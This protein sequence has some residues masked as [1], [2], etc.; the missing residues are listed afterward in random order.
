MF[1]D[2]R[3]QPSHIFRCYLQ[4]FGP[5]LVESRI[6]INGVPQHDRIDHQPKRPELIF[7]SLTVALSKLGVWEQPNTKPG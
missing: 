6:H 5:Q 1:V 7:L 3:R 4:A 2:Q